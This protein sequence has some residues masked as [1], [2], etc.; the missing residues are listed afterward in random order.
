[1]TLSAMGALTLVTAV[2]A[3]AQLR[4]RAAPPFAAPA[5]ALAAPARL[6]PASLPST[7]PRPTSP[8]PDRDPIPSQPERRD[9]AIARVS[10]RVALCGL[11]A[12]GLAVRLACSRGIWLDEATTIHQAQMPLG[13]ML[14][15]L[16]TTDVHPP[17]YFLVEWGVAHVAGTGETAMRAQSLLAGTALIAVMY[18]L[19]RELYDRRAGMLAAALGTLA[20]F[21]VWYSQEA[22]MYALF[23]LFAALATY[24]QVLVFRRGA[25]RHWALYALAAAGLIWTQYFGA[26]FVGV[27]QVGFL[28]AACSLR[29]SGRPA[30]PF[31][32]AWLVTLTLV[33]LAV[34]PVVPFALDQFQ[35]NQAAGK[36]F[37][38]PANAGAGVSDPAQ[39][40]PGIYGLLT[41]FAWG[42][43]GYHSDV[44]MAELAALWP[45]GMLGGLLALGRDRR[46][47]SRLL[48]AYALVPA[49]ALFALGF[50][51]PFVFEI[52]YF[53]G[54]V[55]LLFVLLA[56]AATG[57]VRGTVA[58]VVLATVLLGTLAVAEADQQ[59]NRSNPRM[60]DFEG[61]IE[62][63]EAERRPGDVL[64]YEPDDLSD[65][66]SYYGRGLRAGPLAGGVP[67][68]RDAGRVFLLGSFLTDKGN[69]L[70]TRRGLA[71]LRREWKPLGGFQR[72]QVRVWEFG[73]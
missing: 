16:R 5:P 26:L 48:L 47:I 60:Y 49:L 13:Q 67:R 61:A 14:H 40:K 2:S 28:V 46:P 59:L 52:R 54:A 18:L 22:R 27:Q 70:A 51:K 63:I 6:P 57:W 56:R 34:L 32:R 37:D 55:P 11:L 41:N 33:V 3:L 50:A 62:K 29:R 4:S 66:I 71:A 58:I 64:L 8:P 35:A 73:K 9:R 43:G 44:T 53:C 17:L 72:P 21:L 36:G 12:I 42:V 10:D 19:G 15:V 68:R 65:L 31:L 23:M 24:A 20:P 7:S 30:W 25:K 69:V 39:S 45:L 1:V 38:A